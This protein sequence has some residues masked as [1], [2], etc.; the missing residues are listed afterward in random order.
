MLR[1]CH[2]STGIKLS[3]GT[4]VQQQLRL[5]GGQ[6]REEGEASGAAASG[7]NIKLRWRDGGRTPW[8]INGRVTAVDGSVVYFRPMQSK[9]AFAYIST[10]NKWS[11]LPQFP[12]DS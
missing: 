6:R 2:D 9:S 5:R 3:T 1:T 11:E 8:E 4:H 10:N 7:G 12:N